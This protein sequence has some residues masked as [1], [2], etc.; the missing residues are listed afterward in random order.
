M[1]LEDYEFKN[2][3][4]EL[5]EFKDDVIN[6]VNYGKYSN[7]V[8]ATEPAWRG[9]GGET[10]FYSSGNVNRWYYYLDDKWNR[11]DFDVTEVKGWLVLSMTNNG[12]IL[13]SQNVAS[14]TFRA[15]GRFEIVWAKSFPTINY[16]VMATSREQ[17]AGGGGRIWSMITDT[18]NN[19]NRASLMIDLIQSG[20]FFVDVDYVSVGALG[21]Q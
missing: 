4:E 9:N 17:V 5:T 8:V 2:L 12:A 3:P 19:P 21:T 10:V 14:V 13:A 6:I 18:A 15:L 7:G 20:S 11:V 1:K 16:A